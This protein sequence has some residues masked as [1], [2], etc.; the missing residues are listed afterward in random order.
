MGG[1]GGGLNFA[2]LGFGSDI[3]HQSHHVCMNLRVWQS[4]LAACV[5][6]FFYFFS[7]CTLS[8]SCVLA[9]MRGEASSSILRGVFI[10]TFFHH[11]TWQKEPFRKR[12][13]VDVTLAG[14]EEE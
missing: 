9:E 6:S 7:F 14:Q 13:R 12:G 3:K 2:A 10:W 4:A 8:S 5:T 1:V 11:M